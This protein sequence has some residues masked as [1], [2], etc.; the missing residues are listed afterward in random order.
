LPQTDE[1]YLTQIHFAFE[2]ADVFFPQ[3]NRDEWEVASEEGPFTDEKT[4]L[5]YSY[6][7]LTKK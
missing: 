4:Q 1:L 7:N 3:I 6:L 2:E 5:N